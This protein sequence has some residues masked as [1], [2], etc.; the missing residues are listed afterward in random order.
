MYESKFYIRVRPNYR[1]QKTEVIKEKDVTWGQAVELEG[2]GTF[3]EE[4][5]QGRHL[6]KG[7]Q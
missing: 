5:L 6:L 2:Q 7:S 1:G 4:P 3:L